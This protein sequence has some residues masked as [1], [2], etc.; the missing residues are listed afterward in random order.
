[1]GNIGSTSLEKGILL[2]GE[3]FRLCSL[4]LTDNTGCL[5]RVQVDLC[6]VE[7]RGRWV[8]EVNGLL[9]GVGVDRGLLEFSEG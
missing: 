6:V 8:T 2:Q 9:V 4:L 5:D 3:Y 1:M 7:Q